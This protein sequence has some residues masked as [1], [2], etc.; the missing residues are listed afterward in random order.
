MET[1][2]ETK[3]KFY[4]YYKTIEETINYSKDLLEQR[5]FTLSTGGLAFSFTVFSYLISREFSLNRICIGIIWGIYVICIIINTISHKKS[6]SINSGMKN[7]V[8]K[9]ISDPG[10][11]KFNSSKLTKIAH[12]K[13]K[14]L[15]LFNEIEFYLILSNVIFTIIFF[16]S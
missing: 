1:V 11:K 8:S 9:Q 13:S 10:V 4:N 15:E 5:L 7:E 2:Q 12:K 6:I 16:F 14:T 3:D